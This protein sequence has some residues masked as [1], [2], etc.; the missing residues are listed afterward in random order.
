MLCIYVCTLTEPEVVK[1]DDELKSDDDGDDDI[2]VSE[3]MSDTNSAVATT[4]SK[5]PEDRR[6]KAHV[7]PSPPISE[8]TPVPVSSPVP[9]TMLDAVSAAGST[10]DMAS[11]LSVSTDPISDQPTSGATGIPQGIVCVGCGQILFGYTVRGGKEH[12]KGYRTKLE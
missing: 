1:P 12:G 5:Q 7:S 11:S 2:P 8:H 6:N 10:V 9:V 4:E 3:A